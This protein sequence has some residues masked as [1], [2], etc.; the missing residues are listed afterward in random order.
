MVS[1]MFPCVSGPPQAGTSWMPSEKGEVKETIE[2]SVSG[3][4]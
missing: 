2:L 1:H 3:D 4:G